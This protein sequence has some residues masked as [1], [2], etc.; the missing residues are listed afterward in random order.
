M[1]AA[2]TTPQEQADDRYDASH[3]QATAGLNAADLFD[4]LTEAECAELVRTSLRGDSTKVLADVAERIIRRATGELLAEASRLA[5]V[6]PL[7]V[8]LWDEV[9][10]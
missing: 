2:T 4:E 6:A 10:A 7:R 8:V 9:S 1:Q 3:E 5:R